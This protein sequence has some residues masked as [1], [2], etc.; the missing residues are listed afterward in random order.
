MMTAMAY[1]LKYLDYVDNSYD[2]LFGK[3][4]LFRKKT[5]V[6]NMVEPS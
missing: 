1:F 2:F 5:I 3:R 4:V 6:I